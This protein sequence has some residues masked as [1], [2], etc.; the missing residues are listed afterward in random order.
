M[1]NKI[2]VDISEEAFEKLKRNLKSLDK[3]VNNQFKNTLNISTK[4]VDVLGI[5]ERDPEAFSAQDEF[6]GKV[7]YYHTFDHGVMKLNKTTLA[8]IIDEAKKAI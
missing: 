4:N 8:S 5:L 6:N 3:P 2:K 7:D 1:I